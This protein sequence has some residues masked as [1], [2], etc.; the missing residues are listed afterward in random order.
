MKRG[1]C[2]LATIIGLCGLS[3]HVGALASP[4]TTL[5]SLMG[6]VHTY[7][8]GLR[9]DG[10]A[11]VLA[12]L[13]FANGGQNAQKTYEFRLPQG[14][15]T[16]EVMAIQMVAPQVCTKYAPS[17]DTTKPLT[18]GDSSKQC[19]E[20]TTRDDQ[21]DSGYPTY[22]TTASDSSMKYQKATVKRAGQKATVELPA[23]VEPNKRG[24]IIVMYQTANFA[25]ST[26]GFGS[27]HFTTL[28]V[29]EKVQRARVS[30]AIDEDLY[31]RDRAAKGSYKPANTNLSAGVEAAKSD[32]AQPNRQLDELVSTITSGGGTVEKTGEGLAK[33]E[34]YD[35]KF[36]YADAGWKLYIWWIVGGLLAL[37]VIVVGMVMGYKKVYREK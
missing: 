9:S 7:H 25:H 22:Y 30:V 21:L 15:Q 12:M 34:T 19:L 1:L 23:A 37:A 32:S 3:T 16:D 33:N 6:Q 36:E 35:V 10:K 20:Y 24:A 14:V 27:F 29:S 31:V 13:V 18:P 17:P 26:L 28:S 8:V 5:A 4:S 11:N 2:V